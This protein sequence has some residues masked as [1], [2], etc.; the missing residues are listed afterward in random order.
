MLTITFVRYLTVN[1]TD[2]SILQA[3]IHP[4]QLVRLGNPRLGR[5]ADDL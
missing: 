5:A 1:W 2:L 3:A 4:R